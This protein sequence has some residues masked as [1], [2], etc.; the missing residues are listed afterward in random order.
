MHS[1]T[2]K[3][4]THNKIL[5]FVLGVIAPY[6]STKLENLIAKWQDDCDKDV[7]DIKELQRKKQCLKTYY[8]AKGIHSFVQTLLYIGY[9]SDRSQTHSILNRIIGQHLVYLSADTN[10]E[11]SWSDLF[12]LNFKKSSALTGIIF[13]TLELSA[14][15]LQF[16]QWWQNETNHGSLAKLPNPEPP[17]KQP[18]GQKYQR[19]CP[20]C[21]QT[22]KI[23][24]IN[25]TSG[26]VKCFLFKI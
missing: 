17:K 8:V 10:F 23:P 21:W 16:V 19:I 20:I 7:I 14:Y 4:T 2:D 5:A 3:F 24:T 22:W 26:L 1:K 9:L 11:W 6:I 12:T 25:R 15:F 18:F 13:H